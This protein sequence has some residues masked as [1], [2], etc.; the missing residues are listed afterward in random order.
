MLALPLFDDAIFSGVVAALGLEAFGETCREDSLDMAR[1][2]F[3]MVKIHLL[4]LS[5][6]VADVSLVC[7]PGK[8]DLICAL[9]PASTFRCV[10]GWSHL[11]AVS[12][13]GV[14]ALVKAP[15]RVERQSLVLG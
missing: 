7:M 12:T 11:Q 15:E 4:E 6:D 9:K 2:D 8:E 10:D 3:S 1:M 13:Q 14:D 5:G